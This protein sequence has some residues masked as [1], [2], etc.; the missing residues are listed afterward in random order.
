LEHRHVDTKSFLFLQFQPFC[1][2]I[3]KGV[4]NSA[5]CAIIGD[6]CVG[7]AFGSAFKELLALAV[8]NFEAVSR[9]LLMSQRNG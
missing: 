9:S 8:R 7:F 1:H 3:T 6:L 4:G 2:G 5:S